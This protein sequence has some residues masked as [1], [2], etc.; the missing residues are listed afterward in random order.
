M[1]FELPL[2]DCLCHC[3]SVCRGR[4]SLSEG[5]TLTASSVNDT[6]AG[7]HS[8]DYGWLHTT[9]GVVDGI[10]S[11]GAWCAGNGDDWPWIMVNLMWRQYNMVLQI[12]HNIHPTDSPWGRTLE[13]HLWVRSLSYT[14]VSTKRY[15][16]VTYCVI[17]ELDCTLIYM[18]RSFPIVRGIKLLSYYASM[19]INEV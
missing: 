5:V 8:A 14:L 16:S 18:L 15:T 6:Y 9:W 13:C 17:T 3:F 7:V 10:L 12:I 1:K 2:V 19:G 4:V 11:V